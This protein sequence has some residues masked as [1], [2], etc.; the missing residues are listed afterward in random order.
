MK[1]ALVELKNTSDPT[2]K[3]INDIQTKIASVNGG[4]V[5]SLLTFKH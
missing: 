4:S 3:E 2:T 5:G 1:G